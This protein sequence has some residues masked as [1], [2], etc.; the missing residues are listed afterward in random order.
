MPHSLGIIKPHLD[1]HGL[2]KPPWDIHCA[3]IDKIPVEVLWKI[4]NQCVVNDLCVWLDYPIPG[5]AGG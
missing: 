2:E 5:N 4:F 3:P 1:S